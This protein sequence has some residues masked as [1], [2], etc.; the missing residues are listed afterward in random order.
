MPGAVSFARYVNTHQGTMFYVSNRKQSEYAA[1]V[2]NMQKLGFTGMSEKTVLLSTD[3][4]NK[5]A[6]FDAIKR[7]GYDIVVYAGDNLNDFGAATY[8]R[9]NAQRRAFVSENGASSAPNSSCCPTRCTAI[10][11]AGWP[12]TTTS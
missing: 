7:A 3:T 2:A 6:R 1:T 10:G 4:S 5:Q 11:K 12:A 8:H 9:D